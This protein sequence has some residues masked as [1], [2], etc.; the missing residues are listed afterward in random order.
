M[1][2]GIHRLDNR[3]FLKVNDEEIEV[4]DYKISSSANGTTEL[5]VLI[6]TQASVFELLASSEEQR[7]LNQ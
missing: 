2:I 1:D 7:K 6:R 5:Q 4:S 3:S